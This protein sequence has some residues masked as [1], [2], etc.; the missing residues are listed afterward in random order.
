MPFID[1]FELT[2]KLKSDL[3]TSHIPV[4]LLT[5][6]TGDESKW[7]GLKTGAD[8]YIEKPFLPHILLQLMENILK[9]RENLFK[10][11]RSDLSIL[12]KD[13]AFVESDKEL[14]EKIT[15]LVEENIEIPNLDVQFILDKIGISRSLLH[16]KMK[17]LTGCS[18]T[19]FVRSIRLRTAAKL[20]ADGKCNI[21]QAAFQT[22]FSTP[23]YFSSRF[24]EYFGKSPKE[25]FKS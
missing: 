1:G 25:Y 18:T 11:F 14:I 17:K 24:K 15:K 5:A 9:T 7:K 22:G 19:E 10:R 6:K 21:S 16:L 4:I 20:I 8:Y 13:V 12:P 2:R 3:H 23:A